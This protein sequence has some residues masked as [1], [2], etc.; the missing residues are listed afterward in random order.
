[1]RQLFVHMDYSR[2]GHLQSVLEESGIAT[3]VK[4]KDAS[5]GMGE[6]PYFEVWPE[7][8]VL[9]EEDYPKAQR[10]VEEL[11]RSHLADIPAWTCPE[12]GESVEAGF[13]E[14]WNCRHP[15]AEK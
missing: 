13:S 3:Y 5:I 10:I 14:C 15:R 7:L 11:N 12:C 1:M 9:N 2:V 6:I 8:W 4:N